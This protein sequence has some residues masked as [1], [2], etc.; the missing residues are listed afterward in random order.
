VAGERM[1]AWLACR[2]VSLSAGQLVGW[3]ACRLVSLSAG[4]LVGWSAGVVERDDGL[5]DGLAPDVVGAGLDALAVDEV[6]GAAEERREFVLH[7]HE[8]EQAP[9]GDRREGYEDVEVAIGAHLAARGRAEHAEL[10]HVPALAERV[11]VF[12]R[13]LDACDRGDGNKGI[14]AACDLPGARAS[15]RKSASMLRAAGW[16]GHG[17][18][19]G[20]VGWRAKGEVPEEGVAGKLVGLSA[21][22][23]ERR[24]K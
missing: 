14:T 5:K 12:V 3:L 23:T 6:D 13:D 22:D 24:G 18:R 19:V 1:G 16:R 4:Q 21:R 17:G 15:R 8:V 10:G 2:L 9:R 7:V 20:D 11:Q